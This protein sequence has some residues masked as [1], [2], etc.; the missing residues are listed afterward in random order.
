M[1]SA[2]ENF[3]NLYCLYRVILHLW[4][5]SEAVAHLLACMCQSERETLWTLLQKSLWFAFSR[6]VYS[7]LLA[8]T[9]ACVN[10]VSC[11]Q[12]NTT[13]ISV[14]YNANLPQLMQNK[15]KQAGRRRDWLAVTSHTYFYHSCQLFLHAG[16]NRYVGGTII[17]LLVYIMA[18]YSW[19]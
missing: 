12:G 8:G 4:R 2:T 6:F 1:W 18:A 9:A 10:V 16:E 15:A 11:P 13:K 19:H 7:S 14:R 3:H 5:R 17:N